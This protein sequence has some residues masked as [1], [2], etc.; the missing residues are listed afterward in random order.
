MGNH[1]YQGKLYSFPLTALVCYPSSGPPALLL[2]HHSFGY[3]AEIPLLV[4]MQYSSLSMKT[5]H[6]TVLDVIPEL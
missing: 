5:F 6:P 4:E 2:P 3:I 1:V